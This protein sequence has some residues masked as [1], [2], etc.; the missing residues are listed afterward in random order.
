M[1]CRYIP[2]V[3]NIKGKRVM[4]YIILVTELILY[5]I[6]LGLVSIVILI[7]LEVLGVTA[8]IRQFLRKG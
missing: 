1:N 7:S 4:E 2:T 3:Y 8:K 5:L 6:M